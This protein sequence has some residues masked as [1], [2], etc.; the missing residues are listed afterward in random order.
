M[1]KGG[2]IKVSFKGGNVEG[3]LERAFAS[4]SRR[5]EGQFTQEVSARKWTWPTKTT[6]GATARSKGEIVGSP[7]DIVEF[8]HFRA[9]QVRKQTGKFRYEFSYLGYSSYIRKGYRTSTGLSL[10]PRDW[11]SSGIKAVP[12]IPFMKLMMG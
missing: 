12:F 7:R 2:K 10:P 1:A 11:I 6:R 8:G 9:S 3:K 5:L 4:Y